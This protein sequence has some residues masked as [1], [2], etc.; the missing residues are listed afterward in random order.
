MRS[1]ALCV[2]RRRPVC[3][4]IGH[5][6]VPLVQHE[7]VGVV[8]APMRCEA[9]AAGLTADERGVRREDRGNLVAG[10]RLREVVGNDDHHGFLGTRHINNPMVRSRSRPSPMI[11]A[12]PRTGAAG[13]PTN[14]TFGQTY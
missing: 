3:L 11:R 12:R 1:C 4:E 5:T 13:F 14:G 7:R 8:A 2:V 6:P 10:A 9:Q